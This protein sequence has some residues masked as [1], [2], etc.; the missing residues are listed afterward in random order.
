MR[1]GVTARRS[2]CNFETSLEKR[3]PHCGQNHLTPGYCQA[4]DPINADQYPHLHAVTAVTLSPA[5]VTDN[6]TLSED[7]TLSGG[8][9]SVT[10]AVC[11]ESFAA[12]R[13]TAK[14]CSASC[15]QRARR[16]EA[17]SN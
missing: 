16:Q 15:R 9:V 7:V 5:D 10:C 17:K 3:C 1:T 8:E 13:A 2:N 14:F 6:V 4:L 11:G 12:Q